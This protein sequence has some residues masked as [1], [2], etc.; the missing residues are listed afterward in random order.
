M[1]QIGAMWITSSFLDET[2]VG[3]VYEMKNAA[4]GAIY[5]LTWWRKDS[6]QYFRIKKIEQSAT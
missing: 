5:E 6:K 2:I 1:A 3:S 4:T